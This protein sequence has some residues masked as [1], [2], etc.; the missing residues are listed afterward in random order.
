MPKPRLSI[1]NVASTIADEVLKSSAW[2]TQHI[3]ELLLPRESFLKRVFSSQHRNA[4]RFEILHL[5]CDMVIA[6]VAI[7][8][9][10]VEHGDYWE[11][12]N[13]DLVNRVRSLSI[14]A[15]VQA[16]ESSGCETVDA[17]RFVRDTTERFSVYAGTTKV[18][19]NIVEEVM[20]DHELPSRMSV[21]EL[22]NY[23]GPAR[24][25]SYKES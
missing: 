21:A 2:A 11:R 14:Q 7:A 5:N 8:E 6:H 1:P 24:I 13:S 25:S 18:I 17:N 16:F 10:N 23:L 15:I 9:C 3:G 12:E 19:E 20:K 22:I 4:E